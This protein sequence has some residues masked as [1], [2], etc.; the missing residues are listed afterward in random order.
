M[1]DAI[2]PEFTKL[3]TP[4]KARTYH[5]ANGKVRVENIVA[6]CVRPSGGH[7]L[8]TADGGKWIMPPIWLAIELEVAEWTF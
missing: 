8:E 5:F 6:V 1:S 7:R 4:E 3:T 2:K